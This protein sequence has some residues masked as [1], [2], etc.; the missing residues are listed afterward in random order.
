MYSLSNPYQLLIDLS[1]FCLYNDPSSLST[2]DG[3][4]LT[5]DGLP[6]AVCL[7]DLID[8]AHLAVGHAPDDEHQHPGARLHLSGALVL[9]PVSIAS[10]AV[11]VERQSIM[12]VKV[13]TGRAWR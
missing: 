9:V 8:A 6:F 7:G 10:T 13:S 1:L 5:N 3:V 11:G 4:G 2:D 12:N